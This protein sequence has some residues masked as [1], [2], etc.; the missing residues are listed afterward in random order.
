MVLLDEISRSLFSSVHNSEVNCGPLSDVR[1]PGMPKRAI[2]C[3]RKPLMHASV[4]HPAMGIASAHRV[5]QSTM[6]KRY[7]M[8]SDSGSGLTMSTWR[9]SK[10]SVRQGTWL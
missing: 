10:S 9:D 2:Q 6:V 4:L 5:Y 1:S 7:L 8:D 3:R